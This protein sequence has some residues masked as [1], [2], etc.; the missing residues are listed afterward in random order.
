MLM[1]K[2]NEIEKLRM[3]NNDI[4][5]NI[6]TKAIENANNPENEQL[7]KKIKELELNQI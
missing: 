3:K 4:E 1:E 5:I 2:L 7:K 6:K